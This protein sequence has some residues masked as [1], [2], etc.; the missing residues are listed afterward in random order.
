MLKA[1]RNR[2]ERER[3]KF[4]RKEMERKKTRDL[5]GFTVRKLFFYSATQRGRNHYPPLF[6]SSTDKRQ[7]LLS[8][9]YRLKLLNAM[10]GTDS[11]CISVEGEKAQTLQTIGSPHEAC[12]SVC[13]RSLFDVPRCVVYKFH[14]IKGT[15]HRS[16][17]P[18]I[19][20]VFKFF[21]SL[22]TPFARLSFCRNIRL[23]IL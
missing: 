15:F 7:K 17:Q 13:C 8:G 23:S 4:Q 19:G 6:Y 18:A 3:R 12:P 21:W 5:N 16:R 11:S 22:F 1:C 20:F 14:Q 9:V 10:Y 2:R